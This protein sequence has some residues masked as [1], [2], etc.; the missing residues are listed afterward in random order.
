MRASLPRV[1]SL[2]RLGG[3]DLPRQVRVARRDYRSDAGA[4]LAVRQLIE[5]MKN[6]WM[7][8]QWVRLVGK[9][10]G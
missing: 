8:P 10:G 2:R 7:I 3:P 4:Y 5:T 9:P 1:L 6:G